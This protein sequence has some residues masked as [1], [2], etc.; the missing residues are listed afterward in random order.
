MHA[1]FLSIPLMQLEDFPLRQILGE[2][3]KQEFIQP[4]SSVADLDRAQN[5]HTVIAKGAV[6]PQLNLAQY[7]AYI[8]EYFYLAKD[9]E[10]KFPDHMVKFDWYGTLRHRPQLH[11]VNEWKQHQHH[12]VYQA[13]ALYSRMAYEGSSSAESFKETFQN[14]T[15]AAG[16]FQYLAS[17]ELT[18]ADFDTPTFEALHW[19]MLA[20][21]QE[22]LWQ[23]ALQKTDA[24]NTLVAKLA[25]RVT[26]SYNEALRASRLSETIV[27]DYINHI[28]LKSL[29]YKAVAHYWLA[30]HSLNN[31]DY[32]VQ[33][34]HLKAARDLCGE[35]KKHSRYVAKPVI[36]ELANLDTD[37]VHRLKLAEKD[38]D[39]VY[40]RPVPPYKDLPSLTSVSPA[41]S[42]E[43]E[44]L[45]KRPEDISPAFNSLLPF[46]IFQ[47]VQAQ[48]ERLA[49]YVASSIDEPLSALGRDLRAFLTQRSLPA[50]IDT[51]QQPENIPDSL[52]HHSKEIIAMGGLNIIEDSMDEISKLALECR[53]LVFEC[54][55]RLRIEKY[56]DEM[57]REREGTAKWTRES[58]KSAAA[59]FTTKLEKMKAY[60][61]Q[62]HDSDLLLGSKYATLQPLIA[63]FCGGLATL[64]KAI[65]NC[66][67]A[68]MGGKT[69]ELV[70]RLRSYL[71]EVDKIEALRL[72]E[73]RSVSLKVRNHNLPLIIL[74]EYKNNSRKYETDTGEVDPSKFED[75]YE[76]QLLIF[77]PDLDF[78]KHLRSQ[79]QEL[80]QHIDATHKQFCEAKNHFE[81]STQKQRHE[82]LQRF[83]AAYVGYLELI[84]NLNNASKFYNDFMNR[85]NEV[86][87]DLDH[88]LYS[89]REEAREL[90]IS[91]QNQQNLQGIEQSMARSHTLAAPKSQK[92]STW[93][94]S[95]GIRFS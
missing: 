87:R 33:V 69:G 65:P 85:G 73:K 16:C 82:A 79:Q 35:A 45:Q 63:V 9:L 3:I 54:T 62:G 84:S 61:K 56:E 42:Q 28:T 81:D 64:K 4:M 39:L 76:K 24:R 77:K 37:I 95:Q 46:A 23:Q 5:A 52:V 22:L 67:H 60:L 78:V 55:E 74:G 11:S 43:P 1:T 66:N 41:G 93:D 86:L 30:L 38:N 20:Q 49:N 57:M 25:A 83:E 14:Y 92:A 19:L 34:A 51:I 90:A 70:A 36:E 94:P 58:S 2:I 8:K 26:E 15:L 75:I 29:Y 17:L 47:V 6:D 13:G 68:Q 89:R 48:K 31:F 72:K 7:E 21:A 91:I 40:L 27:Q 53:D 32:G 71:A 59:A 18:D 88:F 44:W 12:L 50:S 10:R 80:E